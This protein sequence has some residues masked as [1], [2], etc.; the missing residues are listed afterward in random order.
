MST[1]PNPESCFAR[2]RAS[3]RC[4]QNAGIL[5]LC[6]DPLVELLDYAFTEACAIDAERNP[7]GTAFTYTAYERFANPKGLRLNAHGRGPFVRLRLERLPAVPGVYRRYAWESRRLHRQRPA[8]LPSGGAGETTASSIQGT[9]TW[10][11]RAQIVTSTTSSAP[12]FSRATGSR[13]G[14]TNTSSLDP[15]RRD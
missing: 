1:R 5:G 14:C 6:H 13:C 4:G 10:A 15:S 2:S 11:D 8:T 7:E 3:A 9:A 12:S